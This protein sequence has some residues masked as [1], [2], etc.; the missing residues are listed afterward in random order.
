[1]NA[2]KRRHPVL[3]GAASRK[4]ALSNPPPKHLQAGLQRMDTDTLGQ[5]EVWHQVISLSSGAG[6]AGAAIWRSIREPSTGAAFDAL[7]SDTLRRG[8]QAT[9]RACV[10]SG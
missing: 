4:I 2:T 6:A 8:A 1:M 3:A 5:V 10:W 9:P 7:L